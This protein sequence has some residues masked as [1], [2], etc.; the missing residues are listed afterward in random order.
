MARRPV[1]VNGAAL[2]RRVTAVEERNNPRPAVLDPR[3]AEVTAD[4]IGPTPG[5]RQFFSQA[6]FLR[7]RIRFHARGMLFSAR[8]ARAASAAYKRP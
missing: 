2:T 6:V 7:L 5:R 8:S 1:S 3:S 4:P